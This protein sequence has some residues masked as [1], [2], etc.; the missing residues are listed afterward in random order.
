MAPGC[1]TRDE[2]RDPW[3]NAARLRHALFRRRNWAKLRCPNSADFDLGGPS[4][5]ANGVSWDAAQGRPQRPQR[6]DLNVGQLR[7]CVRACVQRVV[8]PALRG[9]LNDAGSTWVGRLPMRDVGRPVAHAASLGPPP[10]R[11]IAQR[12]GPSRCLS[13]NEAATAP[14]TRHAAHD[15]VHCRPAL[16]VSSPR[17]PAFRVRANRARSLRRFP[18]RRLRLL[19]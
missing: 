9:R 2:P 18:R 8:T 15:P 6:V 16:R 3:A 17:A 11:C 10:S 7:A 5:T 13:H 4:Q 14:L 12:D 19:S 1:A